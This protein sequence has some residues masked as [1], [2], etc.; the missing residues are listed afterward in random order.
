MPVKILEKLPK[1]AR[2]LW[3]K[4]FESAKASYDEERAAK[5][6]WVAVKKKFKKVN[7]LWV[8]RSSD[9]VN[10]TTT[11]YVFEADEAAI[12]RS[13]D[14]KVFVDYK[15]ASTIV[16]KGVGLSQV[17]L[18]RLSEQINSETVVGRID[19]DSRHGKYEKLLR[20]GLTPEEAEKELQSLETG[21]K[22]VNAV[23]KDDKVVARVQF[24]EESYEKAK[25]F[26]LIRFVYT[27]FQICRRN[28]ASI[29]PQ[30]LM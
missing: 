29:C 6:A 22:A 3:E 25:D 17:A 2:S 4:T 19:E 7:D 30:K 23:V 20:K 9:F 21:I 24:S 13:S 12:S 18:K 8:A 5:I 28:N 27:L 26:K 10:Y 11:R 14:G 1:A 15:L 16:V